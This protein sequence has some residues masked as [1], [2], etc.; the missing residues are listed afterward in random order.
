M[1]KVQIDLTAETP[2]PLIEV[3]EKTYVLV[4]NGQTGGAEFLAG[5]YAEYDFLV[6]AHQPPLRPR[7]PEQRSIDT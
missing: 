2:K 3:L 6:Q 4:R 5:G 1:Y 7:P